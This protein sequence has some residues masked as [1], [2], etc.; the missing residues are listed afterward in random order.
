LTATEENFIFADEPTGNI[1][2]DTAIEII[3]IFKTLAHENNK[4]VI[5]VT[6]SNEVADQ[7]DVILKLKA[8]K[9]V[10]A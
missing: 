3:N 1:D 2:H 5:G 4:C 8:G 9:L 10:I 7:L 6:H